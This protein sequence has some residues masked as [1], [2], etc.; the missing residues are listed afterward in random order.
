MGE[1]P[2]EV[3]VPTVWRLAPAR[4]EILMAEQQGSEPAVKALMTDDAI[5]AI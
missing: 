3:D 1:T 2:F 4:H 5:P